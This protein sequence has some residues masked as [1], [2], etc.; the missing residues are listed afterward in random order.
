MTTKFRLLRIAPVV[1]V[2]QVVSLR[3]RF[4]I[5]T[6]S[7]NASSS[8]RCVPRCLRRGFFSGKIFLGFYYWLV[9]IRFDGI[10]DCARESFGVGIG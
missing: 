4:L 6:I 8:P 2:D 3:G 7:R 9:V 5:G 1:D 10:H